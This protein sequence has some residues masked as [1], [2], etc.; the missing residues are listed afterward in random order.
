M[1]EL[2]QG[3][4]YQFNLKY[5]NLINAIFNVDRLKGFAWHAGM[6]LL[7]VLV[8]Q[9]A[10]NLDIFNLSAGATLVLG[11][12]LGQISKGLNNYLSE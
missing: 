12:A 8:N 11:V 1:V 2:Y 10:N 5:M 3:Q 7:A 9:L 6:M 4:L